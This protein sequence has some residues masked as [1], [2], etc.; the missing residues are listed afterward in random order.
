[1]RTQAVIIKKTPSNEFDQL[2]TCYTED[3]GTLRALARGIYKP[4]S[5]QS[6]HLQPLNL[7]EFELIHGRSMPIISSAQMVDSFSG[8]RASLPA[9]AAAQF[10]TEVLD[11]ISYENEKD[12]K[13][14]RFLNKMLRELDKNGSKGVLP[15]FRAYQTD[16]L[17][18]LGYAP[19][20]ERCVVCSVNMDGQE[21]MIALS[22]ELG[23]VICGECFL[24]TG[25]GILFDRHDLAVLTGDAGASANNIASY[26]AVDSFFEYTVGS[27]LMSLKFL[28][29]VVK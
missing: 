8:L 16:F 15:C 1:M 19:Q 9:L 17:H 25:R 24:E 14:W 7:V 5:I 26:S 22:P 11:R 20:T 21:K 3:F 29:S 13:L 10:F 4:T 18:V 2:V 28:Y 23:G 12:P 6:L 27:Q